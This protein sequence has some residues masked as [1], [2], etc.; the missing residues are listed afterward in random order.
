MAT[1][2]YNGVSLDGVNFL[3]D[4][5]VT[6]AGATTLLEWQDGT[7]LGSEADNFF[8]GFKQ[9]FGF[10]LTSGSPVDPTGIISSVILR[11]FATASSN[12]GNDAIKFRLG[13]SIGTVGPSYLIRKTLAN[14]S[15]TC[16]FEAISLQSWTPAN[17]LTTSCGLVTD[18]QDLSIRGLSFSVIVTWDFPAPTIT[19]ITGSGGVQASGT[20]GTGM[21]MV[22]S[23]GM[24][25]ASDQ[26]VI[27]A[28]AGVPPE[29]HGNQWGLLQFVIQSRLEEKL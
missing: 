20:A 17:L 21:G 5:H 18:V 22:G 11:F 6:G 9:S 1:S 4:W 26:R 3:N 19:T 15:T 2:T 7:H 24:E 25:V 23:G 16:D 28:G 27:A 12:N 29:L 13:G 14:P 10:F 8:G